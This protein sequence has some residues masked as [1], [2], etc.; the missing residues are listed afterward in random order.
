[1]PQGKG[2]GEKM[3]GKKA[4]FLIDGVHKPDNTIHA[5]KEAV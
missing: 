4:L 3:R 2:T 5:I 1:M